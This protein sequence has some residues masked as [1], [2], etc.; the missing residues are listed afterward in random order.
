MTNVCVIGLGKI[1]LPL[2][3]LLAK[4][5]HHVV[6][7]DTN[8]ALLKRIR[9]NAFTLMNMSGEKALIDQYL[10]TNLFVTNDLQKGLSES[11][12]IFVAIGTGVGSDGTPDLSNIFNLAESIC[13]DPSNVKGKL[14]VLKS[15]LPIGTTRKIALLIEEKTGLSCGVG[16]FMAFCP[17]RV[18]GDKALSEM[19]SLPK[20]IGGM[21]EKSS[22]KAA[23]IYG[24]IGGKIVVVGRPE[25]AEMVKLLDNS[26]RQ[27]VF[28]FAN[29]FAL[30]AEQQGINAYE[31][32]KAANDSYPRNNIPF[33]SGGVSGYCLT[34]DPLYLEASFN[35][36]AARRGFNS[37]WFM[38]RQTNDFMPVHM[39]SL[40]RQKLEAAGKSLLGSNVLVCGIAYKENTDDIRNSHG[41]E[42]ARKIREE[43]ANVSLWDPNVQEVISGFQAVENFE[44]V[45]PTMDALV[46]TVKHD[47]F[48]KLNH[49]KSILR[50]VED[51][52]TPVVIDGWGMFQ[53]LIGRKDV[54]YT[55]VGIKC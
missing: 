38:A 46:F 24:T 27:T 12:A 11:E 48:V 47:E 28:A 37:V 26:Y 50:V 9:D 39:V 22:E 44:E 43:G 18:L 20:I 23:Q 30:L 10:D 32:I 31:V 42:I 15:T 53:D 5:N 17:E 13:A 6:G 8:T 1:G 36:I 52:R 40:L 34:K 2:A 54:F 4:A 55:S 45:L 21:N 35:E 49:T 14:L 3:L 25:L 51:M 33:P 16:F 19:A 7:V 41:L 29:D